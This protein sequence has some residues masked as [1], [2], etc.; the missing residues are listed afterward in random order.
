MSTTRTVTDQNGIRYELTA[1]LGR[2]GQGAVYAIKG[3][4]LA[5]KIVVGGN[6]TSRE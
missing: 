6:Q 2:G 3:G 4:R 5:V 1:L